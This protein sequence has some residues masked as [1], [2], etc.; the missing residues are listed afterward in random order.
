MPLPHVALLGLGTTSATLVGSWGVWLAHPLLHADSPLGLSGVTVARVKPRIF[1]N[2]PLVNFVSK[3]TVVLKLKH[4]R[5]QCIQKLSQLGL[6]SHRK[7]F[8]KDVVAKLVGEEVEIAARFTHYASHQLLVDLLG[9][10]L[11]TFLDDVA[12]ELLL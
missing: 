9:V 6:L 8:L 5:L 7:R 11:E 1:F 2:Q 10:V 4:V 12:A 3:I